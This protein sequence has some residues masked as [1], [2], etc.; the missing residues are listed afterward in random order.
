MPTCIGHTALL[1]LFP[2]LVDNANPHQRRHHNTRDHG[3]DN[4]SDSDRVGARRRRARAP[5]LSDH[6][7]AV[8]ALCAQSVGHDA[9]VA[10]GVLQRC[11]ADDQQLVPGCEV[12]SVGGAERLVVAQPGD[13][14]RR[15]AESFTL[16]G[17][18]VPYHHA[19]VRQGLEQVGCFCGTDG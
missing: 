5:A 17:H 13:T 4:N 10:A 16:Q 15:A 11:R 8:C 2:G 12:V 18:R 6:Q 14:R 19:V 3:N 9:R 1:A 7:L